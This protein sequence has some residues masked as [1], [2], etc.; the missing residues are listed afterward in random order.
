VAQQLNLGAQAKLN[1]FRVGGEIARALQHIT[2]ARVAL[3]DKSERGNRKLQ[4]LISAAGNVSADLPTVNRS[5]FYQS[6]AVL[7]NITRRYFAARRLRYRTVFK[8]TDFIDTSGRC[9]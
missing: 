7:V 6:A 5:Y 3:E 9:T 8:D 2:Q 1:D 4:R